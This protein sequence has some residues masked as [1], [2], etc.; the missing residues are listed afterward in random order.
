[1]VAA[2]EWSPLPDPRDGAELFA[3]GQ[4]HAIRTLNLNMWEKR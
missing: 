4:P 2:L 3:W 1:M